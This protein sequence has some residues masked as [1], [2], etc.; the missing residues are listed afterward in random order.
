[1]KEWS[2]QQRKSKLTFL[3]EVADV[4]C[5]TVVAEFDIESQRSVSLLTD[6]YGRASGNLSVTDSVSDRLI[7]LPLW[8]GLTESQ[9]NKVIGIVQEWCS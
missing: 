3:I 6:L 9:Q 2:C 5:L 4:W 1:M 7:R 8:I